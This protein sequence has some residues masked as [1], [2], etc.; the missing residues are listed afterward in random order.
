MKLSRVRFTVRTMMVA[1]AVLAA[2]FAAWMG[3]VRYQWHQHLNT[4]MTWSRAPAS[5]FFVKY[6]LEEFTANSLLKVSDL[7][8]PD[9]EGYY[10]QHRWRLGPGGELFEERSG[11]NAL[12]W[13]GGGG[14]NYL[15]A[16]ELAQAQQIISKLPPSNGSLWYGDPL[17][18]ASPSEGSWVTRVY[19]K[20]TLPSAVQDLFGVL[21]LRLQ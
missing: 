8:G 13:G 20:A 14:Q 19:D 15:T 12:G 17:L 4:E 1:V 6:E 18:V 7:G 9:R 10:S 3:V 21:R 5:Q 16:A 11:R 2:V